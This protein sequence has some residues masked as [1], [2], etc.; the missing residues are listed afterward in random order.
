V[1]LRSAAVLTPA[2]PQTSTI[3]LN[4]M[5]LVRHSSLGEKHTLFLPSSLA[6]TISFFVCR[7]LWMPYVFFVLRVR[8]P[9]IFRSLGFFGQS[10]FV[11]LLGLQVWWFVPILRGL[12]KKFLQS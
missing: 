5:T 2:V 3:F 4:A 12:R 10:L 9:S 11:G 1:L 8:Q 7:L 6:F